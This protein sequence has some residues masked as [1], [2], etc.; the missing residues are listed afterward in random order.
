MNSHIDVGIPWEPGQQLGLAINR[1][2]A[3]VDDWA[4]ILDWDVGL[5]NV[6]WYDLCQRTI[7]TVGH[8]AGLITCMTNRIGCPLQ[9]DTTA[10][11]SDIMDEHRMHALRAQRDRAGVVDDITNQSRWKLS[12][13]FYLTHRE[14]WDKIGGAPPNKFLGFDN[15]YHDRV[16]EAGYRV[17]IMRD[18]YVYHGYRRQ[19]KLPEQNGGTR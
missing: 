4:L 15:W 1:F 17:L 10:P 9:R 14:V 16:R 11:C 7:D 13:F 8:S 12:G 5:V 18:L 2:M 3:K 6:H 19:W